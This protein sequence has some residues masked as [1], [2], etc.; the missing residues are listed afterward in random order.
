[1]RKRP[2]HLIVPDAH[3][4]PNYDNKRFKML[5]KLIREEQPDRVICIGDW[6]DMASL[7]SYDRGKLSFEGK[8]YRKDIEAAVDA[9]EQMM[10]EVEKG[11]HRPKF[12]MF[13]GN[14][15][16]R[17]SRLVNDDGRLAGTIG[18]GDLQYDKF[19]WTVHPFQKPS[20]IDGVT[21]AHF[22][23]SGVAG[24]PISGENIGKTLCNKLH[25]SAVQ[26]HSHCFDH[27]E[28]TRGDGHKIFGLSV[29][30]FTHP[31]YVE[32]WNTAT[33]S[34]WWLGIVMLDELDG[35]GYYDGL[36]TVTLRKLM[37]DFG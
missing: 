20:T 30:C 2:N 12:D 21:Y 19:G 4:H 10:N 32:A 18:L 14:H 37:R 22:F 11:Q 15:E 28:R 35:A 5:G 23:V 34:M 13:L 7:C 25:V 8:R 1:M 16:A 3:N 24:R 9:Q 36:R 33:F 6:A 31:S 27:S 29:G 26:G 17:I